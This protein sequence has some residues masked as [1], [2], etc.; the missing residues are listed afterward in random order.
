MQNNYL[1]CAKIL[2]WNIFAALR[3]Q[4]T[5]PLGCSIYEMV[6]MNIASEGKGKKTISLLDAPQSFY[7]ACV[8]Q[9]WPQMLF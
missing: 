9:S 1:R 8:Y 2:H 3:K 5:I 7:G 6:G 4:S